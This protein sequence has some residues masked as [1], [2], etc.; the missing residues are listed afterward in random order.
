MNARRARTAGVGP[1]AERTVAADAGAQRSDDIWISNRAPA[2]LNSGVDMTGLL[3]RGVR[4]VLIGGH[5]T[6]WVRGSIDG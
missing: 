6:T 5:G 2:Q 3:S 1:A 4:V